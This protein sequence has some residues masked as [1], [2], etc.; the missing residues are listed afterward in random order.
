MGKV[1]YDSLEGIL[2]VTESGKKEPDQFMVDVLTYHAALELEMDEFL[3]RS[4]LHADKLADGR[5]GYTHKIAV[6]RASWRGTEDSGDKLTHALVRFNLLR[7]A[8][9]HNDTAKEVKVHLKK[10]H[11]ATIALDG[12]E[13]GDATPYAL[14]IRI[15]SFMGDDPG[16][17]NATKLLD[18]LDDVVNRQFPKALAPKDDA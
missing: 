9:A 1:G 7:N 4:L 17:D 2:R 18:Q 11:D 13:N 16:A 15:C 8:V 12:D 14:A 5:L 6:V 3:A 10:L